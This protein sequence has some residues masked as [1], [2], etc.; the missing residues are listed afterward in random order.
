MGHFYDLK[1]R[2]VVSSITAIATAFLI[3][4]ANYMLAQWLIVLLLGT[5]AILSVWEYVQLV[6]AKKIELA[7]WLLAILT[8]L[9]ILANYAAILDHRLS[10][11]VQAV[12]VAFFFSVFLFNFYRI[13][14]AI[15]NVAT[16][17]FGALYIAVPIGLMLKIL[18]PASI[19][20][21]F[22]DGRLWLTYLIVVT[23][24]TDMAAYF[25]GKSLGKAKLAPHLSPRKTVVGA[26]AGFFSAVVVSVL[27]SLIS[28][29]VPHDV[30]YMTLMESIVMGSFIGVFGQLGDL[31]ESLLKRDASVKDSN[32]IPGFGGALDLV[33]SLLFTIPIVYLFMRAK[34][35]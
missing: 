7:F 32:A 30:F 17:F 27:F 35:L 10:V 23:K 16:S 19:S 11:L 33:D 2:M 1:K 12:V 25:A 6:K 8:G 3:L 22:S 14:G 4:F 18:Y 29:G 28:R 34:G 24:M 31:A 9:F 26:I 21:H 15:L 20:D 5:L 13:Q